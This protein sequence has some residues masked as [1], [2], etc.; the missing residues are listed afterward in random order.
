MFNQD[1]IEHGEIKRYYRFSDPIF[2]YDYKSG[3]YF[4]KLY[5]EIYQHLFTTILNLTGGLKTSP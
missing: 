3:D 4:P 1:L 2:K 5:K